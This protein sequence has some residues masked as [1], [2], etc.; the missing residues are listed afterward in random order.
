M[1]YALTRRALTVLLGLAC[2]AGLG[3]VALG[4]AASATPHSLAARQALD[5]YEHAKQDAQ[6]TYHRTMEQA[7]Q[8][9]ITALEAAK[10]QAM[11]GGDLNEANAINVA[12]TQ[13]KGGIAGPDEEGPLSADAVAAQRWFNYKFSRTR[14]RAMELRPDGTIGRGAAGYEKRWSVQ[15]DCIVIS[16]NGGDMVLHPCKDGTFRGMLLK[17]GEEGILAPARDN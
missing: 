9:L 13:A 6:T 17:T 8:K 15:G 12:I 5:R 14:A 2:T 16:G 3:L 7:T 10:Q 4:A 11:R 1:R